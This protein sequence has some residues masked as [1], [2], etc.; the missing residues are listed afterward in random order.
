MADETSPTWFAGFDDTD[1]AHV[2]AKGYDKLDPGAA[3]A[4][5]YKAYRSAEKTIGVPADRIVKWPSDD[6]DV[7]GWKAVRAKLGV[8]AAPTD[9]KFD[10][11]VHKD[12]K[13]ADP[14]FLERARALAAELNLPASAAP[15]LAK[16]VI[17]WDEAQADAATER[18]A[19]SRWR[20]DRGAQAELGAELRSQYVP[21]DQGV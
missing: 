14:A 11:V 20:R 8:P 16:R 6:N 7:E 10:G 9:Y 2:V 17:E 4:E 19:R 1:R 18:A 5:L 13:P 12:G 15:T 3:A 21:R